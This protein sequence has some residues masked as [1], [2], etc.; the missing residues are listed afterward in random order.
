MHTRSN[1]VCIHHKGLGLQF[2]SMTHDADPSMH[3]QTLALLTDSLKMK[4]SSST[5][6]STMTAHLGIRVKLDILVDCLESI[7][8]C[9]ICRINVFVAIGEVL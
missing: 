5:P 9:P 1:N 2:C 8:T 7:L 6:A 3:A 4:L